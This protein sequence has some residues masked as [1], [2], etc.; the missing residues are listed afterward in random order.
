MRAEIK[1]GEMLAQTER[2][3]GTRGQLVGKDISGSPKSEPPEDKAP[4]LSDL[5]ITKR[6][7][8]S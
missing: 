5:G 8:V 7:R 2:A 4:T 3:K 6:G 1:M